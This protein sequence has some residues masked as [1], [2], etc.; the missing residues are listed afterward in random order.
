MGVGFLAW[1]ATALVACDREP[2]PSEGA[3]GSGAEPSAGRG[4][5]GSPAGSGG[6]EGGNPSTG[7]DGSGGIPTGGTAGSGSDRGGAGG[8]GEAGSGQA[9]MGAMAGAGGAGTAGMGATSGSGGTMGGGGGSGGNGGSGG[10]A[11]PDFGKAEV[12][13]RVLVVDSVSNRLQ[14]HD[15]EGA[16]VRNYVLEVDLG[17]D[18]THRAVTAADALMHVKWDDTDPAAAAYFSGSHRGL[19]EAIQP[20]RILVQATATTGAASKVKVLTVPGEVAAEHRINGLWDAFQISPR[21]E[22][23]FA[24]RRLGETGFRHAAVFR[25]AGG[26]LVWEGDISN[27]AITRDDSR[28]VFV[29]ADY[30]AP[31]VIVELAT[32]VSTTPTPQQVPFTMNPGVSLGVEAAVSDHAVIGG[33]GTSGGELWSVDWQGNGRSFDV[34]PERSYIFLQ[35]FDAIGS[36]VLWSRQTNDISPTT[37]SRI[38]GPYATDLASMTTSSW[39]GPDYTCFDQP[40]QI[41]FRIESGALRSCACS[42]GACTTIATVPVVT[43]WYPRLTWSRDRSVVMVNYD[44]SLSS[45]PT[46]FPSTLCF[47]ARGELLATI[48]EGWA[49]LDQT[50]QVVL[51]RGFFVNRDYTIVNLVTGNQH[52]IGGAAWAGFVY[53]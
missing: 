45:T 32:G 43:N 35:R 1:G 28:F 39:T 53:E 50:G 40:N 7:G 6:D 17:S 9:G 34:P 15:R 36:R 33:Y 4:G 19:V 14:A 42:D 48:V 22:Y 23:L 10:K 26:D 29:P 47:T 18:Y 13:P 52:S 16:V 11:R 27:G 2:N 25:V 37:P 20:S 41:Y 51:N 30:S 8:T 38:L 12:E 24:V 46:M 44:Y 21:R 49:E 31:V 3:S 5:T